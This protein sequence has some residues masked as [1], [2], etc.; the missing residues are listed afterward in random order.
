LV[1]RW[2]SL[3]MPIAQKCLRFVYGLFSKSVGFIYAWARLCPRLQ[4]NSRLGETLS[5]MLGSLD[6]GH[7]FFACVRVFLQNAAFAFSA[8]RLFRLRLIVFR[9]WL[10]LLFGGFFLLRR[11]KNT[12]RARHL[13][14]FI[15]LASRKSG[16]IASGVYGHPQCLFLNKEG[17]LLSLPCAVSRAL[18][19]ART[20]I[21]T[22]KKPKNY[23]F[24]RLFLVSSRGCV[25]RRFA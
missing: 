10:S 25:L 1:S 20:K 17:R 23:R 6:G 12:V 24:N 14:V 19:H 3:T 7:R 2:L 8:L 15:Y 9:Q 21:K 13:Q 5:V 4:S 22:L 18:S 11:R 16:I